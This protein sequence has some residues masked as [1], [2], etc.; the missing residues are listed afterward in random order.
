MADPV[1]PLAGAAPGRRERNK[2]DKQERIVRAATALFREQGFE[3]TTGRQICER[4]GI[5]TGTL[6]LYVRDKRELLFLMFRPLAEAAFRRVRPG[7]RDDEGVV[8]GLMRLFGALLRVYRGDPSLARLFVQEL[9]FRSD[10]REAMRALAGELGARVADIVAAAQQRGEL[11]PELGIEALSRAVLAHYVF[12]IQLWLGTGAV[13]ARAAERGLRVAL[14][15][16]LQG[17]A[18]GETK[19]GRKR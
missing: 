17:I 12:W 15:L 4:A 5:A 14:E 9:L 11:R 3:A 18:R 1:A 6:F 19:S 16:Q 13:G 2:R 8:D 10:Q 7:L